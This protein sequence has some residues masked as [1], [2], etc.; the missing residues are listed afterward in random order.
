MSE[1]EEAWAFRAWT[2]LQ[3]LLHHPQRNGAL[4]CGVLHESGDDSASHITHLLAS[5]AVR[6][7]LKCI[8]M[9]GSAEE[10]FLTLTEAVESPE[11][12]VRYLRDHNEKVCTLQVDANWTWTTEQ[13]R[14]WQSATALWKI[15]AGLVILV[16][17][18]PHDQPEAHLLAAQL[19]NLIWTG[20]SG[21]SSVSEVFQS[22]KM[23]RESDCHLVAALLDRAP[24]LRPAALARLALP[25][26]MMM[27]GVT[28][29]DAAESSS[30]LRLG[31]GDAVNITM[32]GFE[33]HARE[34]VKIGPDGRLTYL[35]ARDVLVA[36]LTMDELRAL[37]ARDLS[38]YYKNARVVVTPFT[39]QSQKAYVL[40]KVVKKGAVNLY[41]P[42][43]VLEVVAEAGG[44]ET[45]LFQQNTVE[46]A[47]LGRSFVMRGQTRL[48]VNMEAL[49]LRADMTQNALVEPGDYL[50][51]PS[52]NSNEI[53][54][55]GDV[56]MQ[57]TQGLLAHTSVHSAIAQ[58]GGFTPK[59]Y[60]KRVLIIRG[61]LD[62]PERLV[63]NM[64]DVLAGRSKGFRLE[65][66]DIVYVADH[67]WAR[68]EELMGMAINAFLQGAVSS[69]TGANVGPFIK[70][71]IL[72]QLRD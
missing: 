59:A 2:R 46:L 72:P 34:E 11:L 65:P 4:L 24:L 53:Y 45:G 51:F 6:R 13:R 21:R 48:P 18:P 42:M 67:P 66:K 39:F 41:R 27:F 47:D 71:P 15:Q 29:L 62:K 56:K 25:V 31:P 35:Q 49:F 44:L 38:R 32:P 23:Y 54:I 8:A 58:A 3:P 37:L 30:P 20:T 5:A 57:G 55:L 19:P 22:L 69:W 63:V 52:A 70:T 1:S 50:Y 33:G 40:G 7:G 16:E 28:A 36:G 68:A 17:L 64:E 10:F 26:L 61:S 9:V 12:V 60:T 14:V 43:S